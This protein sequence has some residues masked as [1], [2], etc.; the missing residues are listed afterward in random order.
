MKNTISSI[1]RKA[2]LVKYLIHN[3]TKTTETYFWRIMYQ[4]FYQHQKKWAPF[5]PI[6]MKSLNIEKNREK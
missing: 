1:L 6:S 5:V 4:T 2:F 3:S